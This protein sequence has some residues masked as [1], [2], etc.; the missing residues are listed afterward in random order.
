MEATNEF[1]GTTVSRPSQSPDIHSLQNHGRET[2]TKQGLR[3]AAI[4]TCRIAFIILSLKPN[5]LKQHEEL[6]NAIL[7]EMGI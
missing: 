7:R 5:V 3:M 2:Y 6:Q 1:R 4:E